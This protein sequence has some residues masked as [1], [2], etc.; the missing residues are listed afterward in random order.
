[1]I[2]NFFQ[3]LI[4]FSSAIGYPGIIFLMAVESSFIPFPSEVVI[5][6][7][8]Y[9]AALGQLN[10]F[11]VIASGIVGSLLGALINYFLAFSLGRKISYALADTKFAKILLINKSKIECAEK[12]FLR[13]GNLSTFIGRF[14][15]AVRQLISLPAGFSKMNIWAF[16]FYTFLGSACWVIILA[17]LGYIF[18]AN[19]QIFMQYYSIIKYCFIILALSIIAYFLIKKNRAK[20]ANSQKN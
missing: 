16:I 18:G 14:L 13:Y 6:P 7:A 20:R 8:A 12:Y 15:P 1:M 19:M 5:P 3:I 9:L 10:I 4:D 11:L 2:H 17:V